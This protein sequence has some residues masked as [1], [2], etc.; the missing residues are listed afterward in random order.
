MQSLH[1][2][3]QTYDELFQSYLPEEYKITDYFINNKTKEEDGLEYQK[4]KF[5]EEYA[6]DTTPH[7]QN[8]ELLE[9][10]ITLS[11]A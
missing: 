4:S 2:A 6:L 9:S 11:Q 10:T 8:Q 3:T 7:D 5:G 1:L